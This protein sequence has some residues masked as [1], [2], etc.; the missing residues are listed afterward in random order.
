MHKQHV[1][2]TK[3]HSSRALPNRPQSENVKLRSL[4]STPAISHTRPSSSLVNLSGPGGQLGPLQEILTMENGTLDTYDTA[5]GCVFSKTTT[6]KKLSAG[7][8]PL[9]YATSSAMRH[10]VNEHKFRSLPHMLRAPPTGGHGDGIYSVASGDRSPDPSERSVSLYSQVSDQTLSSS[11]QPMES[12]GQDLYS[13]VDKPA[14]KTLN[15]PFA[16]LQDIYSVVDKSAKKAPSDQPIG[17]STQP[18]DIYSVVDKSA[19][20]TKPPLNQPSAQPQDI[21]SVVDKSAPSDKPIGSSTQPQDIYSVVNKSAKFKRGKSADQLSLSPAKEPQG[22]A[23]RPVIKKKPLRP[24]QQQQQSPSELYSVAQK[25]DKPVIQERPEDVYSEIGNP[26]VVTAHLSLSRHQKLSAQEQLYSVVN[27]PPV[28]QKPKRPSP[29]EIYSVVKPSTSSSTS[30]ELEPTPLRRTKVNP[31]DFYAVVEP[32]Q[33]ENGDIY[34]VVNKPAKP[35]PPVARKPD[36]QK[37]ILSDSSVTM[38]TSLQ[39]DALSHDSGVE[40]EPPIPDR[41][42]DDDEL[43]LDDEPPELPPRLY[44]L[45]DFDT[46]DEL[47]FDD[48]MEDFIAERTFENPL[49]QSIAGCKPLGGGGAAEDLNPLYQTLASIRKEMDNSKPKTGTLKVSKCCNYGYN[50]MFLF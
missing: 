41:C 34:S 8:E 29:E 18:Q 27:K 16:Q 49:Y 12:S 46:E 35:A 14:K 4:P 45:S 17:S 25:K 28:K 42:Y 31:A 32:Q 40:D 1:K 9:E 10:L 22:I 2:L 7:D 15:Q 13:V 37:R 5:D 47:C 11:Q 33:I 39:E 21:Y 38:A 19:K 36:R 43:E 48:I 50:F 23:H 20:K 24:Q 26:P 44:S 6:D 30:S 3:Q